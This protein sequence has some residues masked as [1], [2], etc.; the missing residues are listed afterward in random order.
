MK[1]LVRIIYEPDKVFEEEQKPWAPLFAGLL[2]SLLF[3]V[4]IQLLL[5]QEILSSAME[6]ISEL[7]EEQKLNA[8][9]I[10]NS[11]RRIIFG[12][13]TI[14]ILYPLK[15]A[16]LALIYDVAVPIFGG[17]LSYPNSFTI[18]S[19]S[20]YISSLSSL[21]KL[22]VAI[23]IRNPLVR[24]DLGVLITGKTSY[25]ATVASQ[26]DLFTL[27]SLTVAALGLEKYAKMKREQAFT[28][29]GI[30]WLSYI[31]IVYPLLMV[32]RIR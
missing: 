18:F 13:V 11:P 6:R 10:L 2:L 3:F 29:V 19:F 26:I 22:P 5:R 7:P 15:V 20:S 32:R 17:E 25:L 23:I 24:T 4:G 8:L 31:F 14:L 30:L 27:W 28:I 12:L 16:L 9:K 1:N 21:V